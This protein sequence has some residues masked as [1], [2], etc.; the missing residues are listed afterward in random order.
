MEFK[1]FYPSN[2]INIIDKFRTAITK[3]F[4]SNIYLKISK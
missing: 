4:A 1:T 2:R 3:Y